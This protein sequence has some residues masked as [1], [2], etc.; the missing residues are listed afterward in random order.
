MTRERITRAVLRAYPETVR[1]AHGQEMLATLLD[2]SDGSTR[3]FASELFD[4]LRAGLRSRSRATADEGLRRL[5][6]DGF[7]LAAMLWIA[8]GISTPV[9]FQ[10]TRWQFWL[11]GA[12]LALALVGYDRIAGLVG[13]AW[14]VLTNPAAPFG[15]QVHTILRTAVPLVIARDL[16]LMIFLLVMVLAP[17][18]RPRDLQRLLWLAPVAALASSWSL[19]TGAL[20]VAIVA[21]SLAGLVTLSTNPR[22]AIAAALWWTSIGIELAVLWDGA[23][24]PQWI[25]LSLPGP[26][27]LALTAVHVRR[28]QRQ[29]A[30]PSR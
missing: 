22:L 7:C 12:A 28:L 6:A 16:G 24:S 19:G 2:S 13:L 29:T 15:G 4:L 1:R 27:V 21:V 25:A 17:R 5:I 9:G 3:A 8:V 11:I 14:I 26:I 10:P 23:A 18:R 30:R 20:T